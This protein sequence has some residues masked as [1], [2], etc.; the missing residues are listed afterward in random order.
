MNF[1][2]AMGYA[3][4]MASVVAEAQN[5]VHERQLLSA[6]IN[7]SADGSAVVGGD[8]EDRLMA[9]ALALSRQDQ[10]RAKF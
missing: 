1:D 2:D 6:V 3:D 8:D 4:F 7:E 5:E 9:I 10:V